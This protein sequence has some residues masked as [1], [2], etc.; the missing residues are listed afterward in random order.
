M[1]TKNNKQKVASDVQLRDGLGRGKKRTDKIMIDGKEELVSTIMTVLDTRI[2]NAHATEESRVSFH[3]TVEKQRAYEEQTNP[4]IDGLRT[5][6]AYQLGA[7][8]RAAYGVT[9]R[10]KPGRRTFDERVAA[11]QK[12]RA[13]KKAHEQEGS[14]PDVGPAPSP[15]APTN[16][17]ASNG[18]VLAGATLNGVALNGAPKT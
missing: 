4:L 10:K 9:K 8:D 1:A 14:P 7:S 13:T 17:A 11:V 16:G 18:A 15:P 12:L 3:D 2:A 5:M 6:L